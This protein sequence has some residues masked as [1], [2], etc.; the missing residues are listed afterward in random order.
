[1]IEIKIEENKH[2][3]ELCNKQQYEGC[4]R[5]LSN[6]EIEIKDKRINRRG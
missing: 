5:R 1:M 4:Q 6:E 2:D 3:I